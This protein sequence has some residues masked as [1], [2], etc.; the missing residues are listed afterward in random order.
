[1]PNEGTRA[2]ANSRAGAGKIH[3]EPEASYRP[4]SKKNEKKKKRTYHRNIE[5]DQKSSQW[6]QKWNNFSNKIIK[7]SL[8]L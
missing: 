3:G 4:E 7:D 2:S 1:M 8:G 5:V 6:Q